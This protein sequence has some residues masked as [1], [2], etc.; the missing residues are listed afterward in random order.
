MLSVFFGGRGFRSLNAA[1]NAS[2]RPALFAALA[3]LAVLALLVALA[4]LESTAHAA[5]A[6]LNC[7]LLAHRED[8]SGSYASCWGYVDPTTGVE[9]AILA[10]RAGT[11]IYNIAD[12]R[13]PVLTGFIPGPDNLWREMKTYR[14]YCYVGTEGGGGLQIISLANPEAPFLAATYT[15]SSLSSIH[16]VTVDTLNARLYANGANGGCRILSLAVP[17]APVQ[18]GNYGVDYVHDSHVR[19]DTLYAA[20]ISIGRVRVLNVANPAAITQITQFATER[21]AT[22]NCWTTEDRQYVL[23]TDETGGG[24]VTSWDLSDLGAPI[25]VDGFT[26]DANGDAHN[27]HIRDDL[28]YVAHYTEGVHILDIADPADMRHAGYY[29]TYTGGGLFVGCWGVFNYFPSGT[30]VA[31][32]MQSGMFL[33]DYWEDAGAAAGV[34]TSAGTG[35]PLPLAQVSLVDEARDFAVTGAGGYLADARPGTY[36]LRARAFGH[37]SATVSVVI[38]AGDTTPQDFVLTPLPSG[39]VSG[40]VFVQSTGLPANNAVVRLDATPL[41]DATD[42]GGAFAIAGVPAGAYRARVDEYLFQPE[43]L[44][45]FVTAGGD[46]PLSFVLDAVDIAYNFED[47]SSAGWVVN[48]DGTDTATSGGRWV[49]GNPRGAYSWQAAPVQPEDD[50]T[51]DPLAKCWITGEGALGGAPAEAHDVDLGKTTLYSP[52]LNLSGLVAP[53][54]SYWRWYS[55]DAGENPG[56]DAWRAQISSNG[57]ATWVTVDST[58]ATANAWTEVRFA[59][60]SYVQPTANVRMRFIAEDAGGESIVEAGLDDFRVWGLD[61]LTGVPIGGDGDVG[62]SGPDDSREPGAPDDA[63]DASDTRA[64]AEFRLYAATPNPVRA[65]AGDRTEFAFDL[66]EAAQVTLEIFSIDGRR[67]ATL[68]SRSLTAGAHRVSWDARDDAGRALASGVYVYR[69]RASTYVASRKLVIID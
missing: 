59:V 26:A 69:I 60:A 27:V 35:Q 2:A 4:L 42:A 36:T 23:A 50:H 13:N 51:R 39:S 38:A 11:A 20:C 57:G 66:P 68:V 10:A 45:A 24:R 30:I 15:G 37:D 54:V 3:R 17:T 25:Q 31:S 47:S 46:V 63:G 16:S 41:S 43:S 29:Y 19:D 58:R 64:S 61:A 67:A 65:T 55:N 14:E 49:R 33:V 56:Q 21:N 62:E 1:R 32:D 28:A 7:E 48:V 5:P 44:D 9:Y 8:Y 6:S 22:H 12:P 40:S 34:V 53:V 52:V 18:I